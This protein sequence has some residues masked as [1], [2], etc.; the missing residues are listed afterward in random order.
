[1]RKITFTLIA[2]FSVVQIFA[3]K[4]NHTD[5]NEVRYI[6]NSKVLNAQ[7]QQDLR[8]SD[9]WQNFLAVNPN[10]FV[11][12][13]EDN[14]MPHRAFGEPI[15]LAGGADA[16]SKVLNFLNSTPFAIPNDVREGE[17][18]KNEKYI[19]VNFT[20]YYNNL[21]VIDSRLYAKL[22]LNQELI[23][24]GLDLFNDINISTVPTLD[25]AGVLLAAAQGINNPILASN[26]EGE[27]KVLPVPSY[28]KYEYHLV[29]QVAVK[30][31]IEEGPA[32]YTCFVD[33]HTGAL[34][35]RKNNVLYEAPP[36]ISTVEGNLYTT[37]PYNPSSTEKL[38]HLKAKD[39]AT[40]NNYY[41]D[42]NGEVNLPLVL[43][44]QVEYKL[45]GLYVDVRTNGNTP[46]VTASLSASNS[47]LFN[48]TNSTI[49]ER[50]AYWS[51]NEI[52][53]HFKTVFP[54]FTSLDIPM[55][56]NIDEFGSCNAFYNG[57]SINF[58]AAGNNCNATGNIADVVYHEYGHAI[59]DSRYNSGMW[60]GALN[61]GYADIWALSLT[62][63]AVLGIGFY[64]N[65]PNGFVRRYDVDR[66]VY[67]QDLVGEV[68]ADGEIIAGA[69]WDT[70]LAF[71]DM[72]QMLDL[73][74]ATFDGGPDG[75]DGTEGVIYTDILLEVLYAD[76][77][78]AN[79]LNGTPNDLAIVQAFADHGITLLS[80][81]DINH[82]PVVTANANV[83]IPIS[84]TVSMAYPWALSSASCYYR[85]NDA[86][87]WMQTTV[88]I[89]GSA[90]Q[91]SIPAQPNGTVISYYI[92][93]TD[94]YGYESAITPIAA[95][96]SPMQNAN[97]P[98]FIMVGYD[99]SAEEDFDFN[100]GFWQTGISGDNATTGHW[101]MGSPIASYGT[102]GN[103]S[104][105]VQTGTQHTAGG[106]DCA[107]T[108]NA[109][110]TDGV[111]SNDVDGGHT[112]LVSPY[113]DLTQYTNPAFSYWRWYT[114]SPPTGANPGQD[115][116]QVLIT[117]DGVNWHYV[118]NNKSSDIS[119]RKF[120]FRVEDYV[121]LTN[122]VQLKFI[123]SDSLHLGQNLDGGSLVEAAIDDLYL[124]NQKATVSAIDNLSASK[125]KLIRVT[126]L[127]GKEVDPTTLKEHTTLLYIYDN[128]IV[129]KK[130]AVK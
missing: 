37:H 109:G 53:A 128:G 44:N 23:A 21:E 89:T 36:A 22:S 76:D 99:L 64:D 98:Y 18:Y 108:G 15:A 17:T 39:I 114:N 26:I 1:M 41:T 119:W 84:G 19:N 104:T 112:T 124:Y 59:N 6:K 127:L 96:I 105:I 35:M 46:S 70:Y 7:L 31:T 47:I 111:G 95:N 116:W 49:Q 92:S 69:F 56:T 103:P 87:N 42:V 61:E 12:F 80:N 13:N 102:F 81:A 38:I 83:A 91:A 24:F 60:N 97:L 72:S 78:D 29:Y 51:V 32:N 123:A 77:N 73:F 62:D 48:N 45:E 54:T 20:Q 74:K 93:L 117:N 122:S 101:E 115:W 2:L 34:L 14:K 110:A 8:L 52:H 86:S 10:W 82:S 55:E 65:D 100:F 28:G 79:I 129:K 106:S 27:L 94:I 58:Y 3:S 68:H 126:D 4:H 63:N 40:G 16:Y 118:E 88:S 50:T 33:A 43:G 11:I 9:S 121:S 71:N 57:S 130:I 85:L 75:P 66:K 113:F 25:V 5:E 30:T 67:P 120:A 125:P 90:V 107:F